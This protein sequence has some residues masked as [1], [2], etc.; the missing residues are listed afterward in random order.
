MKN[1]LLKATLSLSVLFGGFVGVKTV[2]ESNNIYK[3]EITTETKDF[4]IGDSINKV[5]ND[6]KGIFLEKN[7]ATKDF[8]KGDTIKVVYGQN[9]KVLEVVG[10]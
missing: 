10:Y 2:N 1:K 4:L 8:K 7:E 9:N 6:N 3:Y 5:S